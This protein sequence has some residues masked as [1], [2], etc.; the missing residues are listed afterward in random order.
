MILKYVSLHINSE[1][2]YSEEFRRNFNS[3]C[4]FI[5]HYVSIGIRKLKFITDGTFNMISVVPTSEPTIEFKTIA[6]NVLRANVT[7]NST[8][9]R[10]LTGKEKFEYFLNLLEEGYSICAKY[11]KIPLSDL[12]QIDQEFREIGYKNEW[13]YKKKRFKKENVEVYLNCFFSS[14]DFRLVLTVKRIGSES[15]IASGVVIRTFPNEVSFES[16]FKDVI[17]EQNKLIITDYANRPKFVFK[18]SDLLE[19]RFAFHILDNGL[20]YVEYK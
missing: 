19:G 16:L 15:E 5:C 13:L 8:L 1:S 18:L 3:H 9:Y 12:L 10:K 2:G 4:R 11:K 20:K 6:D 7:L 17:I 14:E